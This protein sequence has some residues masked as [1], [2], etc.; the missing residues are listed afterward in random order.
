MSNAIPSTPH[1]ALISGAAHRVGA[2]LARTLHAMGYNVVVHY[3]QSHRAAQELKRSLEAIRPNSAAL[4][5]SD[6]L[7]T[8]ANVQLVKDAAAVWGRLDALINN[9]SS[10]FPTPVG[11]I[12]ESH[13]NDLVGTNLKAP[14]FLSQ[15]AAPYLQQTGGCIVNIVDIHADR[16]LKNYPLYCAAK[17]G[18]VMLTKGLARELA[19]KVRVNAVAPGAILWPEHGTDDERKEYIISRTALRRQGS[20]EEVAKAVA[21]LIEDAAYI[22][23]QVITVDGGRTLS[24]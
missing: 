11:E 24:N 8:A 21:F 13:W 19:P 16:P 22:T 4:V 7:D 18:L 3:R 14:L 17:A 9:A 2:Q 12:T 1:V 6:L 10:F 23:G 15:A 20:P 5:S